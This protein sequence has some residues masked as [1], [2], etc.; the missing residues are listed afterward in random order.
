[1]YSKESF[2]NINHH[3]NYK[4]KLIALSAPKIM[5]VI[6][7]TPDSFYAESRVQK[8]DQ[9]KS[10]VDLMVAEEVDI[11]DV[12]GYSSRPGAQ[13]V[14]VQ[15][16][17]DRV[18][19]VLTFIKAQ[20]PGVLLS[21]DTFRAKVAQEALNSGAGIINDIAA[22]N[23]DAEMHDLILK[24]QC[25]YIAMHMQGTPATMQNSP[26]YSDVCLEVYKS[27]SRI[28]N[29]LHG[30]GF[31]NLILDPGFGF[32]KTLDHNYEMLQNFE[33]FTH[34]NLPLLA[35]VSRKSM[36]YKILQNTPQ[37]ALNGTTVLHTLLLQK[38]ANIL[39]VHD[40]KAAKEVV[41]LLTYAQLK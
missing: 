22:G 8:M 20:Y 1:M 35:G 2:L 23:L 37:E 34:L 31:N 3:I 27:L 15:E 17:M 36:I 11:I 24:T 16:E 4:G 32:G 41:K 39:R 29:K 13:E 25:V 14:S 9:L 30:S 12:G 40:V 5:G 18:L 33:H 28:K 21:V 26:Q 10:E 6:N 38:G 19:P 7:A